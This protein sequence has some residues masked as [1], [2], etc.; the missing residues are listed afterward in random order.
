MF[1]GAVRKKNSLKTSINI[2]LGICKVFYFKERG[3][4]ILIDI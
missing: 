2:L 4:K 3:L 1:P